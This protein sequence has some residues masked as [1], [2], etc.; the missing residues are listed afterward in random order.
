MPLDVDTRLRIAVIGHVE[1][2]TIASVP[3]LP[4]PGSIV[5][6]NDA[7]WIA[8]G[9]GGIAFHQLAKSPDDIHLFTAFGNDDA[10]AAVRAD[11][12]STGAAIHGAV[13]PQPHTRDL[14]L[15]SPGSERTILV[16]GEPLHPRRSDDLPWD[17]I[18][19]CDAAYFTGQ[20][21]ETLLAARAARLLVVTARRSEALARS[22]V[23]ADV[24]VGSARDP[25]ETSTLADYSLPPSALVMTAGGDAGTI[26]TVGGVTHFDVAK[27][28]ASIV[29][30][31]G[32]GD[33][34]A[35]ALTWYLAR[36]FD[37]QAACERASR[38]A[39]AV[40]A[41]VNPLDHQVKLE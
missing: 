6:L 4:A 32:A 5:H 12:E 37:V 15:V 21:P 13:R 29:G 27:A 18:S 31:Y 26:E 30:T 8:G 25:R 17:V 41:G 39:C 34:F 23:R 38:H 33:T 3:S 9:G 16:I 19:T 20:D 22:G 35:A 36:G 11:V 28:P 1:Y 7:A 10:G 24:I 2:V 40:L 14:V